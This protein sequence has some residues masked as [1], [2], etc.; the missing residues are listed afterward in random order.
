MKI[1]VVI[2]GHIPSQ[3]AHSIN[4][5]K[6][7]NAF[8]NLGHEVE[9][10]TVERYEEKRMKR[11]I[12]DISS[13]YGISKDLKISYYKDNP[14][15]YWQELKPYSYIPLLI[16]NITGNR[17]RYIFDPEKRIS[18]YCRKNT[19]DFCFCRSYRVVH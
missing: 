14:L 13:F 19:I 15:F 2:P 12:A 16:N 6:T 18:E 7:A 4:I 17:I 5:I 3:W 11:E 1:F 8:H 10:L 9:V